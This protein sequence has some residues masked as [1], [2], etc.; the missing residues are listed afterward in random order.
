[1]SNCYYCIVIT[2]PILCPVCVT[3]PILWFP[4]L[5]GFSRVCL[6]CVDS[7]PLPG[8]CWLR[9]PTRYVYYHPRRS[10]VDLVYLP[11]LVGWF[12]YLLY[13]FTHR[14]PQFPLLA[15]TGGW[16]ILLTLLVVLPPTHLRYV[17][18]HYTFVVG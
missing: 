8:C 4:A 16:L 18:R 5:P 15:R 3:F 11:L 14:I 6:H 2:F 9:F 7:S 1:M 17:P 10:F 13:W 12:I